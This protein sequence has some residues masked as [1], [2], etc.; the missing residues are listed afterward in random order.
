MKCSNPLPALLLNVPEIARKS[1]AHVQR[2]LGRP[3]A[4][5]RAP[6][7][8]STSATYRSGSIEVLFL[9]DEALRIVV[10]DTAG[11]EFGPTALTKLGLPP[12]EPTRVTG[13]GALRWDGLCGVVE[14]TMFPGTQAP[15]SHIFVTIRERCSGEAHQRTSRPFFT[16]THG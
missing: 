6:G 4:T 8:S 3:S 12:S 10:R 14:V 5:N 11:L 15:V 13:T 16:L 7:Q 9:D 1:P 2:V